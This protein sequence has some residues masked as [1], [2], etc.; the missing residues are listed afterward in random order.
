MSTLVIS[1]LNN[2]P[3]LHSSSVTQKASWVFSSMILL[4]CRTQ[5]KGSCS[6]GDGCRKEICSHF[7]EPS[8][9]ALYSSGPLREARSHCSRISITNTSAS[10]NAWMGTKVL[11]HCNTTA[12]CGNQTCIALWRDIT[13]SLP[14]FSPHFFSISFC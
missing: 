3:P 7:R 8:L 9:T 2:P 13:S 12:P 5:L 4:L 6:P 10:S 11:S 14:L 1:S